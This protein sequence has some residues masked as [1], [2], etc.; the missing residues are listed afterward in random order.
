VGADV[1]EGLRAEVRRLGSS[2]PVGSYCCR[3]A[4]GPPPGRWLFR[5]TPHPARWS[6]S[7]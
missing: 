2:S 7:W 6:P 4:A 5:S 3:P 1:D